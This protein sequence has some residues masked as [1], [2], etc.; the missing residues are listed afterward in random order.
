MTL[1]VPILSYSRNWVVHVCILKIG[2][3]HMLLGL[4]CVILLQRFYLALHCNMEVLRRWLNSNDPKAI[5]GSDE[6]LLYYM[7]E[8][9]A[10]FIKSLLWWTVYNS[11]FVAQTLHNKDLSSFFGHHA[12]RNYAL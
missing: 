1:I 3:S 5:K 8:I 7:V 9:N 6:K 10:C 12:P 4:L 2:S 11:F